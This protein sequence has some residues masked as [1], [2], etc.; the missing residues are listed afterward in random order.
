MKKAFLILF[1]G[2][3]LLSSGQS[4]APSSAPIKL[5][6]GQSITMASTVES[7]MDMGMEMK[8]NSTTTIKIDIM[9]ETA[10]GFRVSQTLT[11]AKTSAEFMGN[12]MKYDSEKPDESDEEL[13]KRMSESIGKSSFGS[14]D[15]NTGDYT[16]DKKDDE[17]SGNPLEGFMGSSNQ[18]E[19]GFILIVPAGKKTGDTWKDSKSEE[20]TKAEVTYTIKSV[21]GNE[22]TIEFTGTMEMKKEQETQGMTLNIEMNSKSKGTMVVDMNTSLVKSRNSTDT[23]EGTMEAMGQ[24]TPISGEVTTQ[25]NYTY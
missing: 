19:L 5:K 15:K 16:P 12:E 21:T 7:N 22:A 8:N 11:K 17:G 10:D 18:N 25:T 13:S 3:S 23:I 9:D 2:I 6:K 20:G 14:L 1:S 4:A 24:S